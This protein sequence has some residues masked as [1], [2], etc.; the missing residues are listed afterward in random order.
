[1]A[2]RIDRITNASRGAVIAV[3]ALMVA[4][5]GYAD[6][7]SGYE[8]QLA[9]FYLLPISLIAWRFGRGPGMVTA[10]VCIGANLL[11]DATGG[12]PHEHLYAVLWNAGSSTIFYGICVAMLVAL[13]DRLATEVQR[14][15]VDHLTGVANVQGFYEAAHREMDRCRRYARPITVAILDCDRF[16][17][18]NDTL[19]HRAGDECLRAIGQTLIAET[20]GTDVVG[21]IGG[22]EFA[23]V[24]PETSETP[25]R[26]ALERIRQRLMTAMEGGHWAV[27]FSIGAVT[28]AD[29]NGDL[30][31]VLHAADQQLYAAKRSGRNRISQAAWA[32]DGAEDDTEAVA[33]A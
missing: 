18:V 24:M 9:P 14:A 12:L 22:D 3:A 25:G 27:T 20:R 31:D 16:K 30:Q 1:M 6:Y 8:I 15:R 19:G 2:N 11:G 29:A 32:D 7:K 28:V 17:Q 21:R 4:A 23:L 33:A 13:R 26:C 10:F 5:F